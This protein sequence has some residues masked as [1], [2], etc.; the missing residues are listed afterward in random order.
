MVMVV[1]WLDLF[2]QQHLLNNAK[3]YAKVIRVVNGFKGRQCMEDVYQKKLD[4]RI[5]KLKTRLP[6]KLYHFAQ[7]VM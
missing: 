7:K 6:I 5:L 2:K 1:L 3:L 4:A